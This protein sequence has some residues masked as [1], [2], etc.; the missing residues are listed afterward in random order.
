[1]IYVNKFF[2]YFKSILVPL[3]VGGVVGFITSKYMNLDTL[4]KP[5]L[6]PPSI[7]FPIAWGILYVLMGIS[8]GILKDKGLTD[9][10]IDI[11]YYVQL[12][13]NALWSIFFFVL[14]WRLFAFIWILL[15][16]ASV[17]KMTVEFYK[18]NKI[19]GLLQIPYIL[20]CCLW[21]RW[22]TYI[23]PHRKARDDRR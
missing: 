12:V 11:V 4:N 8:Y 15:L 22:Y 10:K 23:F 1:M 9:K 5:F 21:Y 18:R 16:L 13:I 20:W 2:T 7:V 19:S 3:I 17:I 14:K 6:T